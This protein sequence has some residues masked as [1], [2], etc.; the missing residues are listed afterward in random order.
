MS[1][2]DD[3][4][5]HTGLHA[6]LDS[7]FPKRC[8]NCGRIFHTVEQYFTETLDVGAH[9]KGL[10]SFVDDDTSIVVEAFRN[11]PCGSTLMEMFEDPKDNSP[12]EIA[13]RKREKELAQSMKVENPMAEAKWSDAW[14]RGLRPKGTTAF[15]KKCRS[16]NRVFNTPEDFFADTAGASPEKSGLKQSFDDHDRVVIEAY[17]NCPCGSTLM[18]N[19]SDR[20]DASDAGQQRRERFDD[21]ARFL[22]RSGLDANTAYAEL[23]KVFRGGKS[24]ILARIKP[25]D[26]DQVADDKGDQKDE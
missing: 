26:Y 4:M 17:R 16:C 11:C 18:D 13:R 8:T 21:M 7:S 15:P 3:P 19:F 20:R 14:Y 25:P 5:W 23:L 10:K 2:D 12:G 22:I 6:R 24:E 1:A 9:D